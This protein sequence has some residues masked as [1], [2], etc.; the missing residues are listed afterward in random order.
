MD[1]R[2]PKVGVVIC[3]VLALGALVTFIYLNNQFQGPNPVGFA[4]NPF[5]LKAR[6]K[7]NKTM[8][9]KQA[10][11]FRGIAVGTV[12]AVDW[13]KQRRETEITF[14]LDDDFRLRRDAV[15]RIG[16]RS[17]LGDPY[18]AVDTKGS[19]AQPE[20]KSGEQVARTET[21][22]DFDEALAFLD[23]E[24]RDHVKSLIETVADGTAAPG[25]GERLNGTL[26]GAARA[27][28]ELHVL[29]KTL[30][31]QEDQISDL[32]RTSATVLTTLGS[33]ED[34][35]RTIVASGRATLQ[36]LGA[37]AQSLE[38]AVDELPRV[39]ASGRDSLAQVRPLLA[40]SR[41]VLRK[42][43][44]VAPTVA[45]TLSTRGSTSLNRTVGDLIGIIDGLEPLN[46]QARPVLTRLKDLLDKLVPVVRAGAPGARNLVPALAYLTPRAKAIATGYALL[47]ATLANRDEVSHYG[48][49]GTQLDPNES[50]DDPAPANCD[51][52]TQNTPPNQGYCR[53]SYPGPNDS[54]NPQPFTGTYP[55][56]V[57]CTVPSRSTP[58]E[59]CK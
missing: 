13:D 31:G 23:E 46:K 41:P 2:I 35:I 51:P 24:G 18:L 33:Q 9:T 59:P 43:R 28:N 39:L 19:P 40:E 47:G 34:R 21:T 1:H 45:E 25:Q 14:T 26:G 52:A 29:T 54:L 11:L 56:I 53:N 22:V 57:P 48:L 6:F 15:I 37:N 50:G 5:E 49:V 44:V 8:P 16:Y 17:L 36:A 4:S 30:R 20:L 12:T 27:V 3:L 7:D 55:R 58:K 42:L 32:V 10:V 38:E